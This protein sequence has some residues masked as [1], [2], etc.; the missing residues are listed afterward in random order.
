METNFKNGEACALELTSGSISVF[1]S[2]QG[3]SWD[4]STGAVQDVRECR[5]GICHCSFS[6]LLLHYYYIYLC[7][8]YFTRQFAQ[9]RIVANFGVTIFLKDT[10]FSYTLL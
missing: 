5:G 10:F 2:T 3:K 9:N 6:A 4:F 7:C 1:E 8:Q